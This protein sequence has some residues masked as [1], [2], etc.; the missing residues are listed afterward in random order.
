MS[1]LGWQSIIPGVAYVAATTIQAVAVMWHAT[2]V[3][4][5]WQSV[6]IT[7]AVCIIATLFNIFCRPKGPAIELFA[8]GAYIILFIVLVAVFFGANAPSH[9]NGKILTD[10]QDNSGWGSI[11]GAC[12]I[13]ASGP[14]IT[15]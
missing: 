8:V 10:F 1:A 7:I 11:A 3:P 13:G 6:A 4:S 12:F 5:A 15:L 9:F 14:V 2:Y